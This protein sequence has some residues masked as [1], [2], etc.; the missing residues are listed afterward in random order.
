MY[1]CL[2]VEICDVYNY[3]ISCYTRGF[4]IH[5]FVRDDVHLVTKKGSETNWKE[6]ICPQNNIEM[7]SDKIIFQ[8]LPVAKSVYMIQMYTG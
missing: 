5:Y 8:S 3:G 2:P 4:I 1:S 7:V 6:S